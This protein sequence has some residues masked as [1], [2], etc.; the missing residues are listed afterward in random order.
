MREECRFRVVWK[1]I[2][3]RGYRSVQKPGKGLVAGG[4]RKDIP[5]DHPSLLAPCRSPE[6][7]T[8]TRDTPEYCELQR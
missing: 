4:E 3:D 5:S 2:Y 6:Y 1:I 8:Y 7:R